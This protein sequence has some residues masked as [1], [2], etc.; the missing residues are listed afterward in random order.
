MG[1]KISQMNAAAPATADEVPVRRAGSNFRVTVG[2]ISKLS[3]ENQVSSS[4]VLAPTSGAVETA[5]AL[6]AASS[7]THSITEVTNLQTSL[8]AKVPTS[9]PSSATA[10]TTNIT[11]T[12]G[13]ITGNIAAS[14]GSFQVTTGNTSSTNSNSGTGGVI[15]STGA[16]TANSS[17]P[18][19]PG[20]G[21]ASGSVVV[22]TG[23]TKNEFSGNIQFTTGASEWQSGDVFLQTGNG[24]IDDDGYSGEIFLQTGVSTGTAECG[25]IKLQPGTNVDTP[26][27]NGRIIADGFL[28]L[29]IST[30]DPD[31]AIQ[32]DVY[33]NST[34]NVLKYY[35]GAAWK[36]VTAS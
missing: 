15:L 17:G 26:A 19:A 24:L 32:G 2:E 31:G 22:S 34:S 28:R 13:A 35:T 5:L 3:I 33:Y 7:H 6:K 25:D 20:E 23:P 10:A 14:S 21:F 4:T 16:R 12:G 1:T 29:H 8:D 30:A 27:N 18:G 9:T 36:T 11:I